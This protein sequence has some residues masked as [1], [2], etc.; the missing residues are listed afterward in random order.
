MRKPPSWASEA[1]S[2][3]KSHKDQAKAMEAAYYEWN[4]GMQ[5]PR[6]LLP[7]FLG[8]IQR[9]FRTLNVD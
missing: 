4:S 6:G 8:M 9:W 1:T 3:R 5:R 7:G 2:V